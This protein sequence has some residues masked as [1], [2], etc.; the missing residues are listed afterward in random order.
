MTKH[1]KME[2]PSIEIKIWL[3]RKGISMADI[4][5]KYGAGRRFVSSFIKGKVTS[6]EF[7]EFMMKLG[8]PKE[9]FNKGRVITKKTVETAKDC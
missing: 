4:G 5:R 2:N 3:I 6:K 8:C 9:Y 7:T 1:E